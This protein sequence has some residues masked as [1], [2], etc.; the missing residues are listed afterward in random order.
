MSSSRHI[1]TLMH[2]VLA[3]A[4]L[5]LLAVAGTAS[6]AD[7]ASSR[8][9]GAVFV[10]PPPPPK[11]AMIRNGLAIAP[12]GAPARIKHVIVAGNRLIGK[13]YVY[14]GGHRPFA[15]SLDSG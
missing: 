3:C 9:G 15:R 12:A 2:A 10:P 4:C 7:S 5:A 11:K 6:A 13:P 8:T 1:R 14:G